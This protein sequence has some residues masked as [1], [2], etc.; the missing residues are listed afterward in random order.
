MFE[1][2]IIFLEFL[3]LLSVT[4]LIFIYSIISTD[5]FITSLTLLIFIVLII[6]YQILLNKLKILVYE[7]NLDNLLIFNLVFFYSWLINIFMGISLLAELVYLIISGWFE[8][9][10]MKF[11]QTR[12]EILIND[13]KK[14]IRKIILEPEIIRNFLLMDNTFKK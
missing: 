6:P 11:N 14:T 10:F 13:S 5:I 2:N 7:N 9:R 8:N 12:V 1:L 3:L 4:I